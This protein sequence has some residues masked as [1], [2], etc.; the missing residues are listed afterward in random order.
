MNT[1]SE[2]QQR[3]DPIVSEGYIHFNFQNTDCSKKSFDV[4][5]E[6]SAGLPDCKT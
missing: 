3:V 6:I 4:Y 2:E 1:P 5:V